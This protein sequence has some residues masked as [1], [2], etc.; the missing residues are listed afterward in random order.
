MES[1]S[2]QPDRWPALF[3]LGKLGP[4][5]AAGASPV[6]ELLRDPDWRVRLE[7]A[8]TLGVLGQPSAIAALVLRLGDPERLVRNEIVRSL[9][10]LGGEVA[11]EAL[12]R[13]LRDQDESVRKAAREQLGEGDH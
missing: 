10:R 1:I 7:A 13:A 12:K 4:P 5:A 3:A 2:G 11:R 8:R 6:S 9:G